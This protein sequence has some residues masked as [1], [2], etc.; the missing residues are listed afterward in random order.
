MDVANKY[1]DW[2]RMWYTHTLNSADYIFCLN[3]KPP[4]REWPEIVKHKISNRYYPT[5]PYLFGVTQ[6]L[7][8]RAKLFA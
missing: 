8:A 4:Y 5:D 2:I 1:E 7:S 6:Q 3:Q